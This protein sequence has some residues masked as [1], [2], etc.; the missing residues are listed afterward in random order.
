LGVWCK[1]ASTR[2]EPYTIAMTVVEALGADA[3]VKIIAREIDTKVLHTAAR[4]AYPVDP[5][6]LSPERLRSHCLRGTGANAGKMRIKPE[7]AKMIE[8]RALNLMDTS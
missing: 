6:G 8:F 3:P 7:L 5:R 2:E 4:A 1:A